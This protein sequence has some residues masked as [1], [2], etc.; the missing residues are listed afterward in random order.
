M[1]PQLRRRPKFRGG[2]ALPTFEDK[3]YNKYHDEL[4]DT[5]TVKIKA[6]IQK[7]YM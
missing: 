2:T 4:L 3:Q 1:T 6:K 5:L 7:H